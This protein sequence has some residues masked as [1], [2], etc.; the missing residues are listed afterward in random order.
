MGCNDRQGFESPG[1]EQSGSQAAAAAAANRRKEMAVGS[2]GR[3]QGQGQGDSERVACCDEGLL[4]SGHVDL[5]AAVSMILYGKE[6]RKGYSVHR[7]PRDLTRLIG[8]A[9]GV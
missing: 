3:D 4:L 2:L 7:S 8:R 1:S 5:G 9:G 6:G